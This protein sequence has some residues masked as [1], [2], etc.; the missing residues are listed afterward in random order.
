MLLPQILVP[1]QYKFERSNFKELLKNCTETYE[2]LENGHINE[3]K[4][5][6][7]IQSHK[8]R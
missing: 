6:K 5:R 4:F 8:F 1:A 2:W 7:M 3:Q